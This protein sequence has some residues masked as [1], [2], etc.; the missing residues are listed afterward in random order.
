MGTVVLDGSSV[1][2][3]DLYL[4]AHC[5]P[6]LRGVVSVLAINAS[7]HASSALTLSHPA[8]RYTLHATQLQGATVQLNGRTL[9]LSADDELPRIE[10][11]TASAGTIRLAPATIT[12][13]V[14]PAAADPACR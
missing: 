3:P 11:R 1:A 5:H 6:G 13:L 9:A 4:Y 8:E 14:F 2:A 7:R 10:L 12:F